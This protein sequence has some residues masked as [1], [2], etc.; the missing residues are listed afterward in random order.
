MSASDPKA[1]IDKFVD[2]CVGVLGGVIALWCAIQVLESI[3]P[4]LVVVIGIVA[5][6]VGSIAIF[7]W[8]R[9]RW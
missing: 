4:F 1:W 8:Y 2:A 3:L 7:R 9:D 5:L 6:A